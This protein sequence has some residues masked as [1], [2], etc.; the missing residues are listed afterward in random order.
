MTNKIYP[1]LWFNA[2]AEEAARYY[3]SVFRNSEIVDVNPVV[4]TFRSAGQKFM[5]LNGGPKY[6][7]NP[8]ISFY[9]VCET[10]EEVDSYW[11]ALMVG[12]K[13]MM[14][15]DKYDWSEKYG[16]VQDKFGVSWQL[17]LGKMEAVGQKFT[18]VMMFTGDQAGNAEKSMATYTAIFANSSV[19]GIMKYPPGQKDEGLVMHAQYKLEGQVFMCM[20]S[21]MDHGFSFNEAVSFVVECEDQAE[22][23]RFWEKLTD[24]GEESM[25]G[26]LKDRYGISW[27][28]VPKILGQLMGDPERAG[29]VM[30]AFLKMKKFNV[31]QLLEA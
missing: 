2:N 22:I 15:L 28:I 16:W 20:D 5:C 17:A 23:D 27:Q 26:W 13:M 9:V 14:P 4:T 30:Q 6:I 8:S 31:Q 1:C 10:E 19:V 7:I 24:G 21:S 29:R 18:P 25:C 11:N 12:G 3:C